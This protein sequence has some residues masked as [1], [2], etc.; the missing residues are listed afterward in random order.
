MTVDVYGSLADRRLTEWLV[1]EKARD[2]REK[3]EACAVRSEQ[4]VITISRQFGAGGHTIAE[5][6][7][8][9]LG[10]PWQVWDMQIIEAIAESS[11]ARADMIRSLDE[12]T[13]TWLEQTLKSFM[14]SPVMAH[15]TYRRHLVSVLVAIAHQG[16]KIILGRGANCV[17]TEG[18]HVRLRASLDFRIHETMRREHLSLDAA[19]RWAHDVDDR[20]AQ[21]VR[22]M[23]NKE[24]DDPGCYHMTIT[25]DSMGVDATIASIIAA[26]NAR[27]AG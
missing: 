1:H 21:F 7:A 22:T 12:R 9:R 2:E 11:K 8:E 18:L 5:K 24:V 27:T 26:L 4:L 14:H 25:T 17:L 19:Q 13:Q 10:N 23:F 16:R 20:R 3:D 6:L 15:A